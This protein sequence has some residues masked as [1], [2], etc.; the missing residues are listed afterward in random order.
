MKNLLL[1]SIACLFL[2]GCT[3]TT[4]RVS[5]WEHYQNCVVVEKTMKDISDCGKQSR[6]NY[7][8][9]SESNKNSR[10]VV[11]DEYMLWTEL[12][13]E[14]VET[15]ELSE[16][17]AKMKLLERNQMLAAQQRTREKAALRSAIQSMEHQQQQNKSMTCSAI[18]STLYCN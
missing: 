6:M 14:R 5:Y 11:G 16:A 10:S 13:A 12:L 4:T 15:G 1:L 3:T 18:G 8:N 7:I 17:A 2:F 9:E